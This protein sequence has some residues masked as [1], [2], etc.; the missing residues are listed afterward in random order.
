MRVPRYAVK[1]LAS[2]EAAGVR[3]ELLGDLHEE[4]ARGRPRAW[5]WWQLVGLYGYAMADRIRSE[6]RL[7]P[8]LVTLLLGLTL[9]VGVSIASVGRV[10]E[11]WL[12]VYYLAGTLSLF[13]HMAA[14]AMRLE[15]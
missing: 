8:P 7:T 12:V 13:A 14:Q 1:L 4:I 5:V 11:V 10:L 9:L 15:R 3:E 6:G 2:A